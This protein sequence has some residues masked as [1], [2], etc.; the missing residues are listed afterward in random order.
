MSARH[1][2]RPCP[3]DMPPI[4]VISTGGAQVQGADVRVAITKLTDELPSPDDTER[5]KQRLAAIGWPVSDPSGSP[6]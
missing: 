2:V 1:V 6:Q 5:A 3:A 4:A